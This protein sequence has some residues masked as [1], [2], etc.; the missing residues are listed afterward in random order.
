MNVFFYSLYDAKQEQFMDVFCDQNDGM[1]IRQMQSMLMN[2]EHFITQ[3][4]E[5]YTL[6]AVAEMDRTNG[7]VL[8]FPPR[9]IIRL[10]QLR[11][12]INA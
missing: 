7:E 4:A 6:Y 9:S 2:Q 3:H 5:D 8:G 12:K 1:A 10:D 11:S